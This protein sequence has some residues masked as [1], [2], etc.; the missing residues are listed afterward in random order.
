M[1]YFHIRP[2]SDSER[3]ALKHGIGSLLGLTAAFVVPELPDSLHPVAAFGRWMQRLERSVYPS[4]SEQVAYDTELVSPG[5][6]PITSGGEPITPSTRSLKYL[7]AA[8]NLAGV[9]SSAALGCLL[10]DFSPLGGTIISL[11]AAAA[12]K[13]LYEIAGEIG[14]DLANGNIDQARTRLRA[15]VSRDTASLQPDDV[16]RAVIESV[17]ENTVDAITSPLLYAI[18]AGPAG[19]LAYRAVNTLDAMVGYRDNRYREFGWFSARL[20]DIANWL[21]ARITVIAV[22]L[23]RPTMSLEIIRHAYRHG[24]SHPSPNAGRVEA[25][26]AYALGVKLGGMNSYNGD[27]TERPVVGGGS[28]PNEQDIDR[29]VR[30]SRVVSVISAVLVVSGVAASF[31]LQG[32]LAGRER[33]GSGGLRGSR[34]PQASKMAGQ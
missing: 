23:A 9:L 16:I 22:A 11:E 24:A 17:A 8:Y 3:H 1:R 30:L 19:V 14:D 33:R 6:E 34:E 13:A 10:D 15:L 28:A 7:G 18:A 26:F 5:T 32:W 29:A 12:P 21:P 27:L 31:R 2:L 4:G 20:D 25:A